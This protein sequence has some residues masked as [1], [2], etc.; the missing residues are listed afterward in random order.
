MTNMLYDFDFHLEC[1]YTVGYLI[2]YCILRNGWYVKINGL[3][4]GVHRQRLI[5][6]I[7][8]SLCVFNWGWPHS[9]AYWFAKLR[10]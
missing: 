1:G 2:E 8:I 4:L 5:A 9:S 6:P 7:T 10:G 3:N